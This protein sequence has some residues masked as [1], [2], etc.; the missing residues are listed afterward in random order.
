MSQNPDDPSNST[1]S[2]NF[3]TIFADALEKYKK[4][5]KKDI[6][7]HSLA[8]EIQSCKSPKA[9]LAVLQTQIQTFDP[10]PSA[11]ERWT[12]MLDPTITV[13]FALSGFVGNIAGQVFPPATAIFT[14]I[15]ALLQAVKDVRATQDTLVSM[16]D[17]MKNFFM[18]LEKYIT[19]RPTPA[20]TEVIVQV[21]VEVISILGIA[22]K[23]IKEGKIKKF[24]KRLFGLNRLND[25]LQQL[26][27][28]RAEEALMAGAETLEIAARIDKG[29]QDGHV[30]MSSMT[31]QLQ[32]AQADIQGV[33]CE[34]YPVTRLGVTEARDEMH[35][36]LKY[37]SD[38]DRNES[39][40]DLRQWI[41]PPDP[42]YNL[43]IASDRH[44][45]GTA[46]WCT[47]GN[48][49]ADWMAA[50]SLLW[51]HGKPGSGKTILSSV[52]IRYI[53]SM[54]NPASV[55]LAYF[56][57]DFKDEGKKDSRALL[58]SL[59]DQLSDQS[60]QF[61]DVLRGLYSEHRDGSKK[62]HDDALLRCLKDILTIARSVPIYLV[63]DALDECPNDSGELPSRSQR[64]K[65]LSLMEELVNLRLPNLRLC[66][67]SR[68]EVDIRTIVKPIATQEISLHAESGQNRDINAYVT[69]IVQSVQKWRDD[70]KKM[71]I[72]K[73]TENADGMFRWVYCQLEALQPCFPNNLRRMLEELPKSLD[74]TYQRI[75]KEINNANQKQAHQLLQCLAVA[76]RPLRVEEL[77]EVLALDVDAGG[78]PRFNPNW[79]WEDHEAAV[80]SACSSLVSV[81]ID[82]DS[83]VVQFSHFSVK[84]FLTSDRLASMKDVS[85]FH[86]ADEP[87]HAIL[88]QACLGVVLSVDDRTS[89]DSVEDIALLRYA[90]RYWFEHIRV[91]KVE[92]HVK[93]ALDCL[94]D[95]NK[96]HLEAHFRRTGATD[97]LLRSFR[98]P[99][100]ENPKGVLIP[101][102]A[103]FFACMGGFSGLVERLIVP[104]QPQVT[105]FRFQGWTLLHLVV[106]AG[107]EH[108]EVARL[109]LVHGADIN[110]RPDSATP[111][112][113]ASCQSHVERPMDGS[114]EELEKIE[115]SRQN[116]D[117]DMSSDESF[118]SDLGMIYEK[119]SDFT[120]LHIAVSKGYL[121]ICQMLLEHKADVRAL[122][123]S[124][125]TPLH[126]AASKDH[127]EVA[128]ILLKYNA[129][130]NS[131]N[132]DG[133]T[134]LLLIASSNGNI[135]MFR[136]L[137]T[138][139]AD[140][141]VHDNEGNT[142]LHLAAIGGH[143]KVARMLLERKADVN[144]LNKEGSTPLHQAF[145]TWEENPDI[146]RLLLDHGADANVQDKSGNTLLHFAASEGDLQLA[147]VLLER[148]PEVVN[149]QNDD[150]STAFL[151]ALKRQNHDIAWLLLDHNP[152]V[153]AC[154]EYGYTPLHVAVCNG[155][156]DICRILLERN[157]DVNS[158]NHHRSTPLL[159]ASEYGTPDLVQLMLDHNADVHVCDA[160]GDTPLHY[161]T[162]GG[163]VEVAQ[164]LLKL[165]IEVNSRNNKGSTPLHL[166]S[167]GYRVGNPEIVRLLLDHGADA[168]ARNLSG[169]T[170]SE[171]ARGPN[172]QEIVQLLTQ[173]VA[174]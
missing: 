66:I 105:R 167:A 114:L 161:A 81:I 71:V 52:I 65:V 87:S 134:P 3:E 97:R 164:L 101:A 83:R 49:F 130:V 139:S 100:D 68:P 75:L 131:R 55:F 28:V 103:L 122:D 54:P 13:L 40:K 115:N 152:D 58:S 148:I 137:L 106:L 50:G 144:A 77:A 110:A 56:Y 112:H 31:G 142:P 46:A 143:L 120:P 70:D 102:A 129:E 171:V 169:K 6:A 127:L 158:Q 121:D 25:A 92:L 1:S 62:P 39:R 14:G 98:A 34:S 95:P 10:S 117:T 16:F 165:D 111:P 159:L 94:F 35:V 60:D 79:R 4:R 86:I 146:V 19:V 33:S 135:D 145:E 11:N 43:R 78:I 74:E 21:M 7:T 119:E 64:G 32:S 59:L 104:N 140:A 51:I 116:S 113:I 38:R 90:D 72:D 20:M 126:L 157:A 89:E 67:T 107:E 153:H 47:Q 91:G 48:T 36:V 138:H 69:A 155:K 63:M 29:V 149:S 125:N 8:A 44:Y 27:N 17:R 57:F 109:L 53:E 133:S 23:E 123:N 37:V 26:E 22:T 124:G 2:P 141:F 85:Q 93:D 82:D 108:I 84:E 166:A 147:R 24:S 99:S 41:N 156:L 88:A 5:T 128:R 174:E 163:K 162:L 160:D 150:G 15:G 136:L 80:L 12:S 42:S 73:L 76:H 151:L 45:A 30:I 154:D 61:R 168:Q 132:E 170:A 18:R 118:D 9:V 172:E 96:P 173:N